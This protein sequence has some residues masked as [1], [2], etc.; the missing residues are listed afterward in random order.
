MDS[1]SSVLQ[2]A[3]PALEPIVAG[4]VLLGL[5]CALL[6]MIVLLAWLSGAQR[7]TT[8]YLLLLSSAAYCLSFLVLVG[9]QRGPEPP[10]QVCALSAVF[11][12]SAP[13]IVAGGVLLFVIELHLRM[14]SILASKAM[15]EKLVRFAPWGIVI[16][17]LI[18]FWTSLVTGLSDVTNI[19]RDSSGV[20]CH[21]ENSLVPTA[22]TG[23]MVVLYMILMFIVEGATVIH[24][25]RRRSAVRAIRLRGSYFPLHLFGRTLFFTLSGGFAIIIV[26]VINFVKDVSSEL[27]VGAD[28]RRP[29]L[30]HS[31]GMLF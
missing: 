18:P 2:R 3:G 26:L 20:F 9:H 7:M 16:S 10:L 1:S 4:N 17:H 24:L 22:L 19:K 6:L 11:I 25:I 31:A 21:I 12:Y 29:R 23:T 28:C 30:W 14:T 5:A 8:W 13:P 27:T 15:G